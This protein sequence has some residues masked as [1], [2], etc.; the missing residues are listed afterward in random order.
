MG[1]SGRRGCAVAPLGGRKYHVDHIDTRYS[2]PVDTPT[3]VL[4]PRSSCSPSSCRESFQAPPPDPP[5]NFRNLLPE[6]RQRVVTRIA[7]FPG[8]SRLRSLA[9]RA[10]ERGYYTY[11]LSVGSRGGTCPPPSLCHVYSTCPVKTVP[12]QIKNLSYAS[13]INDRVFIMQ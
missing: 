1:P 11:T 9:G 6:K 13:G 3:S 7:S 5:F 8:F 2:H 4:R 12:P 10:W